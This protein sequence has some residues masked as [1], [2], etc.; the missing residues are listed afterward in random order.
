ML[1]ADRF[2]PLQVGYG[3]GHLEDAGV[4]AG[5]E[6]ELFRH[7]LQQPVPAGVRLAELPD[8]AGPHVGVAVHLGPLEALELDFPRLFD[9]SGNGRRRFSFRPVRQVPVLD[10]RHLDMDVDPIEKGTGE[11]GEILLLLPRQTAAKAVRARVP[12][13]L[14][15]VHGRDEHH[16]GGVGDGGERPG[17][18]DPAVLQRLAQ[19]FEDVLLEL[20]LGISNIAR[21][22]P[23]FLHIIPIF[24]IHVR[25]KSLFGQTK[26]SKNRGS[27]PNDAAI[28]LEDTGRERAWTT[29]CGMRDFLPAVWN[30]SRPARSEKNMTVDPLFFVISQRP[31]LIR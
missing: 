1:L 12:G 24:P 4:G 7:H 29:D 9:P 27:F 3:A 23:I 14:A 15:G 30:A 20:V 11:A 5:R 31:G 19:D 18:G 17:D 13:A 22:F 16:A 8:L 25:T 6:A 28:I 2:R 10:R 26:K 21:H